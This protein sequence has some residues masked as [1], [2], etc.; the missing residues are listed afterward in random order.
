MFVGYLIAG[1]ASYGLYSFFR[2]VR[3]YI[4]THK[5]LFLG[6]TVVYSL[7]LASPVVLHSQSLNNTGRLFLI[8]SLP[9]GVLLLG[10]HLYV[11]MIATTK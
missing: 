1:I 2:N 6:F 5:R 11:R 3:S 9:L 10:H 8:V 4:A 7:F